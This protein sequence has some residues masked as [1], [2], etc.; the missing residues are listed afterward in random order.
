VPGFCYEQ[1]GGNYPVDF[2]FFNIFLFKNTF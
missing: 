2:V 1:K